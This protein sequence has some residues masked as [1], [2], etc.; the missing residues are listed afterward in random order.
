[1]NYTKS[2][3]KNLY[4][5]KQISKAEME[6]F[7]GSA[8][9]A[10][11]VERR[12]EIEKSSQDAELIKG[13][14]SKDLE[15][16]SEAYNT[17]EQRTVNEGVSARKEAARTIEKCVSEFESIVRK[18]VRKAGMSKEQ[19]EQEIWQSRPDLFEKYIDAQ[20]KLL[21]PETR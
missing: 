19:M 17:Y 1:M 15:V 9:L 2:E 8:E 14:L 20:R 3:I 6:I 4:A 16:S 11:E 18:T 10:K 7:L 13:C 12:V 21:T 5:N